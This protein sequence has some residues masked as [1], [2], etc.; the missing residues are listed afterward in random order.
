MS[1]TN[2]RLREPPE[3]RFAAPQHLFDLD[4]ALAE[5]RAEAHPSQRGRR[6]I[7]LYH[8]DGASIILFSFDEGG[9]LPDHKADGI[10]IIRALE[11]RLK[12]E[13]GGERYVLVPSSLLVLAPDV[14]H[15][16]IATEQSAL[17]VTICRETQAA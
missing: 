17:L 10:V 4:S 5:L 14:P 15:N 12:V 8:R 7:M 6:Q 3:E 16:V 13:A 9:Q 1:T 11:G 2:D